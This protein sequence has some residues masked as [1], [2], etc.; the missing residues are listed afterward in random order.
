MIVVVFDDSVK[1]D[2]ALNW[3]Q[4]EPVKSM[5]RVTQIFTFEVKELR[6]NCVM[7]S[8]PVRSFAFRQAARQRWNLS[9]PAF[10]VAQTV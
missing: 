8:S 7:G 5:L 6:V 10:W 1:C 4:V 2:W 3:L 9:K